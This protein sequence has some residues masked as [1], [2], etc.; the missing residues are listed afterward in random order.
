VFPV[1][2]AQ[3]LQML[4]VREQTSCS[5]GEVASGFQPSDKPPLPLD[6]FLGFRDG[7]RGL[8]QVSKA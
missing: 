1:L 8:H 3:L 2:D 6:V 7:P 5:H 4:K